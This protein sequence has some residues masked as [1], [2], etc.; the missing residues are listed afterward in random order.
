MLKDLNGQA[1]YF[2]FAQS[3]LINGDMVYAMPGGADT[4]MVAMN[5]FNGDLIWI[6]KAKGEHPAYNSPKLIELKDRQ[7]LVTYSKEHFL[8]FDAQNG[9]L[10]WSESFKSKYPNHANTVLYEDGAIYTAAT[11]GHGFLKYDLSADGTSVKKIWHDTLVGNYFGGMTK[12]D[13]KIYSGGGNKSKDLL[14]LDAHTGTI[15]DSLETG[16]GSVIYADDMLYTY[17]HK[18][19]K[20]CLVDPDLFEIKG[21]FKIKKGTKEHFSH[22]VI[23]N[24]TLY[25]RHGNTLMAYDIKE[26]ME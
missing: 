26:K 16:N 18:N 12:L 19:G 9:D 11:I 21:E 5:R 23:K 20:V 2:G 25:I 3:L 1:P 10:L 13:D 4:N 17:A 15:L 14:I 7:L 22:P 24:G 8:G 6:S